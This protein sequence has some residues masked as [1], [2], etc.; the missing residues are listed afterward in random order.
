MNDAFWAA[1]ADSGLPESWE[2]WQVLPQLSRMVRRAL[3][4]SPGTVAALRCSPSSGF[5]TPSQP[6]RTVIG[7]ILSQLD[8]GPPEAGAAATD[9]LPLEAGGMVVLIA[10]DPRL[11][12]ALPDLSPALDALSSLVSDAEL[13]RA[14]TGFGTVH[15]AAVF[16]AKALALARLLAA[17]VAAAGPERPDGQSSTTPDAP[18]SARA[19]GTAVPG[20]TPPDCDLSDFAAASRTAPA[21]AGGRRVSPA[22]SLAAGEGTRPTDLRARLVGAVS[23]AAADAAGRASALGFVDVAREHCATAL[24]LDMDPK[25]LRSTGAPAD[26]AAAAFVRDLATGA[27]PRPI[28]AARFLRT[29]ALAI[30]R[31][32]DQSRYAPPALAGAAEAVSATLRKVAEDIETALL[33]FGDDDLAQDRGPEASEV[34]FAKAMTSALGKALRPVIAENAVFLSVCSVGPAFGLSLAVLSWSSI[35]PVTDAGVDA[36]WSE[37][38]SYPRRRAP[39]DRPAFVLP[40]SRDISPWLS[41]PSEPTQAATAAAASGRGSAA[42]ATAAMSTSRPL[43]SGSTK[44]RTVTAAVRLLLGMSPHEASTA[45][46]DETGD[47]VWLEVG[48]AAPKDRLATLKRLAGRPEATEAD[49]WARLAAAGASGT[50]TSLA[51]LLRGLPRVGRSDFRGSPRR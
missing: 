9:R 34:A 8:D 49:L 2:D 30:S 28:D 42:A 15:E 44:P 38:V 35:F 51:D 47:V 41:V 18:G 26:A 19:A 17:S 14:W 29:A 7:A 48:R 6:P 31:V 13:A 23:A 22:N 50:A 36:T 5:L 40:T 12:E 10:T 16:H 1:L 21:S 20:E 37:A 3:P 11:K 27:R 39:P 32:R 43:K 45:I 25:G 33:S 46:S 24:L 4:L